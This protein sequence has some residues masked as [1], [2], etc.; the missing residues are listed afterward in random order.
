MFVKTTFNLHRINNNTRKFYT[1]EFKSSYCK[2]DKSWI[3][4]VNL[5]INIKGDTRKYLI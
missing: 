1:V 2:N 4:L 3:A 5:S